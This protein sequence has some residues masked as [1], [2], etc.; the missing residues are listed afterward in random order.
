MSKIRNPLHLE[1]IPAPGTL[2]DWEDIE[3]RIEL[4]L[5]FADSIHI[6]VTDGKFVPDEVC[7]DPTP[8]KK[9]AGRVILEAHFMTENPV[10]YVKSFADCG[11]TRF[12]GQV[13]KMPDITEFVAEAQ[14]YGEAGLGIDGP[15]NLSVLDTVN[16]D[17]ID[18]VQFYTGEKAGYS[19]ATMLP[20]RLEKARALREKDPF[21]AIEIDGGVNDQT[22]VMAK[23]AGVTRF[24][25]TGFIYKDNV[26][27]NF[28]KLKNSINGF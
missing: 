17:D 23:E 19:G 28:K 2:K 6:D 12:I 7:L 1:I 9:Y 22:I 4:V 16:L 21:I 27:E 8:F 20:D 13:E 10:Q 26:E 18:V 14:L 5:P 11:F 15:T 25:T 3:K 24:V